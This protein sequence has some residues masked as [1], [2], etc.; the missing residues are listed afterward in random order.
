MWFQGKQQHSDKNT[1]D[2]TEL[3]PGNTE[4]ERNVESQ[5][6]WESPHNCYGE[7]LHLARSFLLAQHRRVTKLF[8]Y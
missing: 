7:A 3:G 6:G 2:Q 5:G 8:T 4:Q 1:S